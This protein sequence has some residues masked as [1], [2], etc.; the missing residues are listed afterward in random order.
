L[1]LI[2]QTAVVEANRNT[3]S[4]TEMLLCEIKTISESHW[5]W[6]GVVVER[7]HTKSVYS[8]FRDDLGTSSAL[9]KKVKKALRALEAMFS[10]GMDLRARQL[11][12]FMNERPH[13]SDFEYLDSYTPDNASQRVEVPWAEAIQ[14][15][16]SHIG[17]TL[18]Q[19]I[20]RGV[21]QNTTSNIT[22]SY[23]SFNVSGL[24]STS[25]YRK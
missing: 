19:G 15:Y 10:Q 13:F 7:E 8:R 14:N 18:F 25:Q 20:E 12:S 17:D 4:G 24:R 21:Y 16:S 1:R 2:R 6:Q 23:Q 3:D 11:R 22:S 5:F 9:P